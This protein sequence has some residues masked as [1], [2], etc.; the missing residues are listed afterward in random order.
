MASAFLLA[1]DRKLF[2]P[3]VLH[4][5]YRVGKWVGDFTYSMD[6]FRAQQAALNRSRI[7]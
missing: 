7:E 1:V 6:A 2:V 5:D 3:D 4:I